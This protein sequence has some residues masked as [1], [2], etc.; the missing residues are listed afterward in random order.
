MITK[1]KIYGLKDSVE[2]SKYP[3]I[4][5]LSEI[6]DEITPRTE[7]LAKSKQGEG[8]DNFLKGIIV[9]FDVSFTVKCWTE[10]ERYH[11]FDIISSQ[12]TMHRICKFD[13]D[14]SYIKYV[15]KRIIE[16]IK[17]KVTKYN[18]LKDKNSKEAKELYLEILYNNPT[19]FILMAGITTN[20]QQLKTIY[21][22]RKNHRLP[23]WKLF[24]R[25]IKNLPHSNWIT[26]D[27]E[28]DLQETEYEIIDNDLFLK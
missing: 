1:T 14:K 12:S 18:S 15:D 3:M 9:Q 11:W 10:A 2:R 13:L 27:T 6:N 23:E 19:G 21:K 20:Y 5:D 24:C 28:I 25:W 4:T 26:D 16:I 8:H 17:E 7:S 22:Q